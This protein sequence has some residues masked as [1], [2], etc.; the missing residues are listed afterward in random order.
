M[1]TNFQFKKEN[2]QIDFT[3]SVENAE[4]FV[5]VQEIK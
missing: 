4:D 3:K 1:Q 5:S 2:V